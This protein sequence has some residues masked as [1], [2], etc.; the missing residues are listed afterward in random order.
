MIEG[1]QG[2]V[3][4]I[5]FTTNIS[6]GV[7]QG[8]HEFH[9]ILL[10]SYFKLKFSKHISQDLILCHF[11]YQKDIFI[12]QDISHGKFS[13]HGFSHAVHMLFTGLVLVVKIIFETCDKVYVGSSIRNLQERL[14][15]HMTT[16]SSPIFKYKDDNPKIKLLTRVP[17][18]DRK[19]FNKVEDE[20]I[21]QYSIQY[22][23]R[24][25]NKKSVM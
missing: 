7:S 18:K 5:R 9:T 14:K 25:L 17:C 13:S 19:E 2:I 16:K 22:G 20:D 12:S 23:D 11:L 1:S 21:R 24:L 15:E 6:L 3:K 8:E 10:K 4:L